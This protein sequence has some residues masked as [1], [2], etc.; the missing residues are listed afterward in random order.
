VDDAAPDGLRF[1]TFEFARRIARLCSTLD[2][3]NVARI[4]G[5]QCLRSGTSIGANYREAFRSRSKAEFIAK[6]GDCL[7]E[8][9]ETLY[10]LELMKAEKIVKEGM[11]DSLIDENRELTAIFVSS[12]NTAKQNRTS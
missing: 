3:G 5:S 10:W 7:K 8:T 4:L 6:L 11:L 12:L 1:R 2:H 9:E